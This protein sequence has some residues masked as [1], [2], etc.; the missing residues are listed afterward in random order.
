M[1]SENETFEAAIDAVRKMIHDCPAIKG[2]LGEFGYQLKANGAIDRLDAAHR[3]EIAEL[4]KKCEEYERQPELMAETANAAL[5][6]LKSQDAKIAE[7]RECLRLSSNSMEMVVQWLD[8]YPEWQKC[9][10]NGVAR[11]RKALEVAK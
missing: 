8:K 7:L 3:R 5:E 11:N 2:G 1:A 6:L 9:L 4:K 10:K